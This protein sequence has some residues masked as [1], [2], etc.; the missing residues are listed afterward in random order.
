[1]DLQDDQGTRTTVSAKNIHYG[2]YIDSKDTTNFKLIEI[3]DPVRVPDNSLYMKPT[4]ESIRKYICKNYMIGGS[5]LGEL[6]ERED[7]ILTLNTNVSPWS[8]NILSKNLK[9]LQSMH[10]KIIEGNVLID[11]DTKEIRSGQIVT[12]AQG[13]PY[14]MNFNNVS[15]KHG[16]LYLLERMDLKVYSTSDITVIPLNNTIT[17]YRY[18]V[19]VR[20][21][22]EF[23]LSYYGLP[24]PEGI[25]WDRPTPN[26]IWL[27]A[28][29]GVFGLLAVLCS[30]LRRRNSR[31]SI[32]KESAS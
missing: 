3:D 20:S 9:N 4:A 24:E 8:L 27:L 2:F 17:T 13:K 15:K 30:Y 7:L 21:D 14:T 6:I 18:N 32:T 29:C 5:F 12:V 1:M 16:L 31:T 10:G 26:Y 11:S 23:R 22:A 25:S 19:T 28:G